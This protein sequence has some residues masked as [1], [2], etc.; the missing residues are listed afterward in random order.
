MPFTSPR[1]LYTRLRL[2]VAILIISALS[3]PAVFADTDL[4][5]D[6][7]EAFQRY[8]PSKYP[9]VDSYP[10]SIGRVL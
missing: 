5:A 2:I 10:R 4:D 1:S 9:D 7:L 8:S 6:V 3:A